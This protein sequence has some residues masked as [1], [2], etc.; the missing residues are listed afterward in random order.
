MQT[1]YTTTMNDLFPGAI[2]D[3][4]RNII[5]HLVNAAGVAAPIGIAVQ[6]TAQG[7]FGLMAAGVQPYGIIAHSYY[8]DSKDGGAVANGASANIMV[9]G[10][11]QVQVETPVAVGDKAFTRVAG[12]GQLG[13]FRND[14]DTANAVAFPGYFDSAADANG[15][16]T[17]VFDCEIVNLVK[18]H[19]SLT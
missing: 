5:A 15:I 4:R 6:R 9:K 16:A 11:I 10:S 1:T 8:A 7:S 3:A 14:A 18:G 12:T 17:L 2:S 13:A 19:V